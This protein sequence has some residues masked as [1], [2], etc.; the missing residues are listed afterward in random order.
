MVPVKV[1]V[2]K[3]PEAK[4]KVLHRVAGLV[5]SDT[6][7]CRNSVGYVDGSIIAN[8]M[9]THI[10]ANAKKLMMF[11]EPPIPSDMGTPNLISRP[12]LATS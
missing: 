12:I 6:V 5:F 10:P 2:K 7:R 3:Y 11:A 4:Q 1:Q 8:I 9:T